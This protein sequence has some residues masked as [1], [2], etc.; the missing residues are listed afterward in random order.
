MDEKRS[1]IVAADRFMRLVGWLQNIFSVVP[2]V[3][4]CFIVLVSVIMRYA[5]KIPFTWGGEAARY[6]MIFAAMLAIGMGVREKAHLGVT[7]FTD[8]MPKKLRFVVTGFAQ[9]IS[10]GIYLCLTYLSWQF[11]TAQYKFGQFS[12]ALKLP[13]YLVY[14]M[15]LLGFGFSCIE[16]FYVFYRDFIRRKPLDATEEII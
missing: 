13:M 9:L 15:L 5:L 3:L 11:I 16:S 8:L 7:I 12:A 6:W 4:M 14:G 10:L 1:D 2:L